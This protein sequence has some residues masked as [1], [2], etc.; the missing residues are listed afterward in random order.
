ML[1]FVCPPTPQVLKSQNLKM[2]PYL[3]TAIVNEIN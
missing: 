3:E 1:V 2:Q